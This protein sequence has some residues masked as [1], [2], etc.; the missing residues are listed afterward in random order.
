MGWIIRPKHPF[1]DSERHAETARFPTVSM[2]VT[3]DVIGGETHELE[4]GA[5]ATYGDVLEAVGLSA[6]EASVLVDDDPVPADKAVETHS[7]Q[8]IRLIKGG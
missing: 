7:V 5:E 8:V 1:V 2:D 4:L 6:Q 3:C